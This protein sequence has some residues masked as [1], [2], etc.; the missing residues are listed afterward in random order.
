MASVRVPSLFETIRFRLSLAFA[1]VVFAVGSAGIAGVFFYENST[2]VEPAVMTNTVQVRDVVTDEI[3]TQFE[4]VFPEEE[5]RVM[6][7]KVELAAYRRALNSLRTSSF[8]ALGVLFFAAFVSGWFLSGW[9]LRPVRHITAVAQG[10]TGSDLGQRIGMRGPRD[11]LRDMG[12]TFDSMLDRLEVAFD[13]QRRFVAEAS[14]ELRN[15][16]AVA[17]TNLELALNGGE[18]EEIREAAAIAHE[19]T[20]RMSG[21]VDELLGQARE[22]LP[23]TVNESL[24]LADLARSVAED[25]DAAARQ[26][27]VHL[28]VDA[29]PATVTGDPLALRRA[30]NNLVANAIRLAP[31]HSTVTIAVAHTGGRGCV[32]VTDEGPGLTAK[33]RTRVFDRFWQGSGQ[34]G[35]GAGLGLAIVKRIAER[36][37]GHA[38][39]FPAAGGS[40]FV[41]TI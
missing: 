22:S 18:A 35:R 32:S 11:E 5:Q 31:E 23:V 6:A 14:H 27:L 15:P 30:V 24:D 16:L 7:E 1:L 39:V 12:D 26:R 2:L 36:H 8:L 10:I 28:E 19:A 25:Y 29:E 3:I 20:A 21:M 4:Y 33:E 13:D 37:G 38:E 40:R 41:I 9:A 17:R 34:E